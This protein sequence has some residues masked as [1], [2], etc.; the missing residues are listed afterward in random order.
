MLNAHSGRSPAGVGGGTLPSAPSRIADI[1]DEARAV[2]GRRLSLA[3][4]N[5]AHF[6]RQ[7]GYA[8]I[9]SDTNWYAY[10]MLQPLSIDT[11]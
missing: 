11:R 2:L 10:W 1:R 9:A 7:S 5:L 4:S 8:V 6:Q 3:G